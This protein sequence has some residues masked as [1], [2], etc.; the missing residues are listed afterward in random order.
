MEG[1]KLINLLR[2]E[3][4]SNLGNQNKWGTVK[5]LQLFENA[6]VIACARRSTQMLTGGKDSGV[7]KIS[8][9]GQQKDE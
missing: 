8:T 1:N 9:E 3:F 2:E 5:I 7:P 4:T 6:V